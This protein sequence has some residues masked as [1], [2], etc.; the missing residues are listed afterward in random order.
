MPTPLL[1]PGR[2]VEMLPPWPISVAVVIDATT[3]TD[4]DGPQYAVR[5]LN[6]EQKIAGADQVRPVNPDRPTLAHDQLI[7]AAL[8]EQLATRDGRLADYQR[9]WNDGRSIYNDVARD[10]LRNVD[11]RVFA[12]KH[13]RCAYTYL[14]DATDLRKANQSAYEDGDN[15]IACAFYPD[16]PDTIYC[17]V[18]HPLVQAGDRGSIYRLP[19]DGVAPTAPGLAACTGHTVAPIQVHQ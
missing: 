17:A 2:T 13:A 16:G 7:A 5:L 14:V 1:L 12:A 15:V 3:G 6:G 9:G 4:E 10:M 11:Q 19:G 8:G 18:H